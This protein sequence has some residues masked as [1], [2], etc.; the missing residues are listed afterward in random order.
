MKG[1]IVLDPTTVFGQQEPLRVVSLVP[2]TTGSMIDLGLADLLVGCTSYCE[3]PPEL[4]GRV[5]RV[6]G[7]KTLLIE[8]VV[9]L[10]P[11]LVIANKEE[12]ARLA[13]QELAARDMVVW[14][15]FPNTVREAIQD[16]WVMAKIF[17][18]DTAMKKVD[19]LERE[20][21]WAGYAAQS[22]E[23]VR[24]FCPIW[25]EIS[26]SGA[27]WWM[28][29]NRHSFSCDLLQFLGGVNVFADRKR[30]YPL[31]AEFDP[32]K[33]E[34]AGER[35]TRY[36][37]VSLQEIIN[38]KP[39]VIFLPNEPYPFGEKNVSFFVEKLSNTPA[40][41]SGRIFTIDGSLITWPGTRLA[42]AISEIPPM[43]NL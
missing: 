43:F 11:D 6:G 8:E 23:A 16:L 37:R 41:R 39:E 36:P 20:V 7:P 42:R 31:E 21:E 24:F 2:S 25:Q 34:S 27:S 38:A 32:Q 29:F 28:T 30:R 17:R 9:A 15:A 35:D 26:E 14:L 10:A 4:E 33:G 5:K 1:A 40:V 22:Q 13:V 12:N 3:I 18:S 19:Q